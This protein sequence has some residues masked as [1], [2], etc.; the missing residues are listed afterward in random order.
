[1]SEIT[2]MWIAVIKIVISLIVGIL[3]SLGGRDDIPKAIRRFVAP[4]VI[5]VSVCVFSL[6]GG[7]FSWFYLLCY[8]LFVG[9]YS[10]GYGADEIMIKVFNRFKCATAITL[11][12][13]P[14]VIITGSWALF[15]LQMII[16]VSASIILGV[17]NPIKAS[18]EELMIG[19]L[20][21]IMVLFYG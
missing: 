15:S 8:P 16:S 20:T 21:C 17:I 6:F 5:I 11:A 4:A 9:A 14:I 1:M 19:F 18:Q 3:Y 7:S 10:L 2:L 12:G 13:L